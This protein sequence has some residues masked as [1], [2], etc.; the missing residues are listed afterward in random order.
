MKF[1]IIVLTLTLITLNIS[2]ALNKEVA[3]NV[4]DEIYAQG[5]I[6][7]PQITDN[8]FNNTFQIGRDYYQ[9]SVG[10][11]TIDGGAQFN[12][13]SSLMLSGNA[14]QNAFMPINIVDGAVNIP[15]NIVVIMGDNNG[16]IDISNI[17]NAINHSNIN[18]GI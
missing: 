7:N 15:I 11:I 2:N 17:L 16:N 1:K 13:D 8:N 10:D 9:V 12:L 18:G 5:F 6:L 3:D 4:L 14:Q